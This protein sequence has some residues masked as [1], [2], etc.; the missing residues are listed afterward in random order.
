MSCFVCSDEEEDSKL[1]AW[2][3]ANND[4]ED[5][6]PSARR[7]VPE[8]SWLCSREEGEGKGLGTGD[9]MKKTSAQSFTREN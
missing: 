5:R 2:T 7:Q 6:T 8:Q 3:A 9:A 1:L 4:G